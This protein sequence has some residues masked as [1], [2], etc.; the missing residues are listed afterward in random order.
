MRWVVLAGLFLTIC[1]GFQGY[2][3]NTS[4]NKTDQAFRYW[5]VTLAHIQLA[6]GVLLY[7]KSPLMQYY[8]K[9][10]NDIK[11]ISEYTFFGIFHVF[12]MGV[13]V[14]ILTI[15]SALTKRKIDDKQKFKIILIWFSTALVIIFISIPWSFSPLTQ[16]PFIRLF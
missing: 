5:T 6:I 7:I 3:R 12:M 16:R 9:S 15:G 13:A 4:F 2:F 8:W 11:L 10:F 1:R 14:T